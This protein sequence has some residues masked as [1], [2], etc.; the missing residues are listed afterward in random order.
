MVVG[1]VPAASAADWTGGD[2]SAC[3]HT[4]TS[5]VISQAATCSVAGKKIITCTA[6]G[7]EK[8]EVIAPTGKHDY[9]DWIKVDD[10]THQRTCQNAGC[11]DTQTAS[12]D[13]STTDNDDSGHWKVCACG[14]KTAVVSHTDVYKRQRVYIL[15]QPGV[16]GG[17]GPAAP[18]LYCAA[19]ASDS[20]YGALFRQMCIR[21][22]PCRER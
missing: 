19:G 6:C 8:T 5:E 14:A 2:G 7:A 13:F 20:I 21:D 9:G 18:K 16:S 12:H 3:E 4:A 22:S 11:N 15:L 10:S 17:G 1:L